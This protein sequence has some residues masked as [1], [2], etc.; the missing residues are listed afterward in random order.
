M[1][2]H[3]AEH[4]TRKV[5]DDIND[6]LGEAFNLLRN[7]NFSDKDK[8]ECEMIIAKLMLDTVGE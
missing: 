4:E 7:D 5:F 3:D 2:R 6:R 8:D 1:N